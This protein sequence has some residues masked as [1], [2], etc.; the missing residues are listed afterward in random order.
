MELLNDI[1]N[2]KDKW[3]EHINRL[4]KHDYRKYCIIANQEDEETEED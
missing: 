3:K 1:E 4:M 2:Y